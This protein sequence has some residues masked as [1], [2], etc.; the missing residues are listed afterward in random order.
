MAKSYTDLKKGAIVDFNVVAPEILGEGFTSCTVNAVLDADS[1][2]LL[3]LDVKSMHAN[4]YPLVKANGI[5]D[6]P[7]TYDFVKVT[8]VGGST[9][10]LWVPWIIESTIALVARNKIQVTVEDVG[11]NDVAIIKAAMES[12]GY[13]GAVVTL[14]DS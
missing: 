6:D 12:N 8:K 10:I 9:A 11:S 3:G 7:N 1:A 13:P 5:P 2:N 14:I 4:L